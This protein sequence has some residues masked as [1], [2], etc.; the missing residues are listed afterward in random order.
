MQRSGERLKRAHRLAFDTDKDLLGADVD[1]GSMRG[2]FSYLLGV[3]HRR[4]GLDERFIGDDAS[5][6][7]KRVGHGMLVN[8]IG[9]GLVEG[10]PLH[11]GVCLGLRDKSQKR[12]RWHQESVCHTAP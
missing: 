5:R 10:C 3:S 4:V 8:G 9:G 2:D 1:A 11:Q 6:C 7:P 12:A